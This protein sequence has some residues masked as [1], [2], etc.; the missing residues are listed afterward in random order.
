MDANNVNIVLAPN[1]TPE[2][3]LERAQVIISDLSPFVN[4]PGRG[5]LPAGIGYIGFGLMEPFTYVEMLTMLRGVKKD[6][7]YLPDPVGD[8]IVIVKGY[9][10]LIE[11]AKS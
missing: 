4:M 3:V 9:A 2:Q 10:E 8:D 1:E 11:K 5:W 7:A 6:L